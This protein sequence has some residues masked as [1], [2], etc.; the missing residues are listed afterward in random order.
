MATQRIES[1]RVQMRGVGGVPMQQVTP[2]QVDFMQASNVQAQG[3]NQLAQMVD[4]MSQSAFT[5]SGQL[6]Q[7]AAV[8]D[9]ASN[10]LTL[11]QLEMAKN[12]DMSQLGVG[13]SPLNI[14]DAAQRVRHRGQ[15]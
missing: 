10:P 8:E 5:M 12:G 4:R 2:R 1:G 14:Y 13:G 3:A 7:Q 9:V 11:E 6:F 15:G